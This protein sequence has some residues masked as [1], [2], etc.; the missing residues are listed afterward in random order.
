MIVLNGGDLTVT[1]TPLVS[2]YDVSVYLTPNFVVSSGG[3]ASSAIRGRDAGFAGTA[4]SFTVVGLAPGT[5][6]IGVDSFY[7]TGAA[8]AG[9]YRLDV[10][11]A[12]GLVVGTAGVPE[13]GTLSL[14]GAGL[15][16]MAAWRR[17]RKGQA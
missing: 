4:E 10:S 2:T 1:A 9:S 5:Y 14:V 12:N 3:Q 11:G 8:A 6:L 16:G 17:R 13:P 15:V 7:S